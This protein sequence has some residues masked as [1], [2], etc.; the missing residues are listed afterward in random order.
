[1]TVRYGSVKLLKSAKIGTIMPW[2]G[3]G[4]V[5][6]DIANLPVGWILCDGTSQLASR[7]PLLASIIADTYGSSTTFSGVFPDYVGT[8]KTPNMTLKMPMDLEPEYLNQ[9]KYQYGVTTA[10]GDLVS[11][12]YLSTPAVPAPLVGGFGEIY[13]I[14]TTITTDVDLDFT[15]DP[16][17]VLKGKFTNLSIANPSFN[18]TLYTINRKLSI[19]HTP[20]HGHPG[21][22]SKSDAQFVAP[23]IFE[24]GRLTT[25]GQIA[26]ECRTL[27]YADCQVTDSNTIASWQQGSAFLTYYGDAQ[28]E[29]TLPTTDRFYKFEGSSYWQNV[30]A[31]N[32]PPPGRHPSGEI[33]AADL[34]YQFSGS[35]ATS[36]FVVDPP[37]KTHQQPAWSGVFPKPITFANRRNHFGAMPSADVLPRSPILNYD[38]DSSTPYSV[39][40]VN[41]PAAAN[42]I[43]LPAGTGIGLYEDLIVPFMWIYTNPSI[44]GISPGTQVLG[45]TR[46]GGTNAS[47]YV[48]K[49]D[50]SE[51]TKNTTSITATV[52]FIH[53]TY[54]TTLNNLTNGLDP[55]GTQFIG[56]NHGSFDIS[57][58]IGSLS[59]PANFP[60]NNISLGSVAPESIDNALNIIADV[61]MPALIVTFMIKA[62]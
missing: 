29:F 20:G 35:T 27:G 13:P 46:I 52:N 38:P 48:Y 59:P 58:G 22:Y 37:V 51:T 16:S 41:I 1:M 44:I 5:G 57:M 2:A 62:Y 39:N 18:T 24:P 12:T 28:H 19:N 8:F 55:N 14:P 23:M 32:W 60:V 17:L 40:N 54:P 47:N 42:S 53:G 34:S 49:L 21:T 25:G 43:N 10:Y 61:A 9:T 31:D 45:I 30:P 3:D 11:N 56:H 15:V 36:A 26:G 4:N 7:Y 50:L 6:F 33:A